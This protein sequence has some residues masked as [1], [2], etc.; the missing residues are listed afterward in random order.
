M[1]WVSRTFTSSIGSKFL[2]SVTG[3]ALVGFLVAHLAGN[4]LVF[5]G[6][7]AMN[8]Y[9]KGLH[10]L[11]A[12]LW[13]ARIGLIAATVVHIITA[14]QLASRNK[15]ANPTP[16]AV[17]KPMGSSY[18][19]RTM[20][21]SGPII[22]LYII[23]HLAHFTFGAVNVPEG[24]GYPLV[25]EMVVGSFQIWWISLIYIVANVLICIHLNHGLQSAFQTLGINHPHF[26]PLI[27]KAGAGLSLLLAIGF[28]SIPLSILVGLVK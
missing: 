25:Y 2:M 15:V 10:D 5:A 7:D 6:A 12:L 4:L 20:T 22:L 1:G 19:S 17:K 18:A 3:L 23:Y 14:I 26:T 28:V 16:Y 24:T 8:A 27:K 13:I 11:G 9:A 21:L